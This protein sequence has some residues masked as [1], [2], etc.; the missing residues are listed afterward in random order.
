MSDY[1]SC[2]QPIEDLPEGVLV[3]KFTFQS[4]SVDCDYTTEIHFKGI[5]CTFGGE[6]VLTISFSNEV[7]NLRKIKVV[8]R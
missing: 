3:G 2:R 6:D 7:A 5:P 4:S 8:Y 1:D